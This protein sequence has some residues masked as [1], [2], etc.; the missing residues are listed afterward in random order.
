MS[1]HVTRA[2]GRR[3]SETP[4]AVM[5]TLASPTLS[6]TGDL[7]VWRVAMTEGQQGPW[8]LFDVEQV[9]LVLSGEPTVEVDGDRLDLAPGDTLSLPAGVRRRISAGPG[10]ELLV[11]GA[12][13]GRAVPIDGDRLGDPVT[14]PWIA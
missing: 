6:G 4:N 14:P 8:H 7:S 2:D 9:W 11:C 3:V 13:R 12:G 10:A 5:T 1:A